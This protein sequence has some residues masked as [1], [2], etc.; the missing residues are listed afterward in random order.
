[1]ASF[2]GWTEGILL[3]LLFVLAFATVIGGMNAKYNE[4]FDGTLGLAPNNTISQFNTYQ[5]TLQTTTNTGEASFETVNGLSLSTSWQLMKA[6]GDIIWG[7]I[8]GGW[9]EKIVSFIGLP[10]YVA[11]IFRILWFISIGFIIITILFKVRP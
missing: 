9:T 5:S 1:M 7:F 11:L 3:S 10:P 6:T 4:N 2:S 8:T